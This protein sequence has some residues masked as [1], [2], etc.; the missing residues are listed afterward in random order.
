M[1]YSP[2]WGKSRYDDLLKKH[3][4]GKSHLYEIITT[5]DIDALSRK[6][7]KGKHVFMDIRKRHDAIVKYYREHY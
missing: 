4:L 5:N 1:E 2:E 7:K 3:K 6:L